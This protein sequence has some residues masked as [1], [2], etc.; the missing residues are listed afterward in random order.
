MF[1]DKG[2]FEYYG[3]LKSNDEDKL[4]EKSIGVLVYF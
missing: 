3:R 4:T 1:N 2:D